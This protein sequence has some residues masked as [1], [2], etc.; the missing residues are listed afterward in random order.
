MRDFVSAHA[1]GCGRHGTNLREAVHRWGL[2]MS[3]CIFDSQM[4]TPGP[5]GKHCVAL[6]GTVEGLNANPSDDD[7]EV[8][9]I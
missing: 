1:V 3:Y 5:A 6:L 4:L 7:A 9:N 8:Q 2:L